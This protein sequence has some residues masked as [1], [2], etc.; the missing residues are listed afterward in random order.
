MA[1]SALVRWGVYAL[2]FVFGIY[3]FVR[4]ADFIGD[5]RFGLLSSGKFVEVIFLSI[6]YTIFFKIV[7]GLLKTGAEVA[8]GPSQARR[9]RR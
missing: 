7:V 5:L 3:I 9:F 8:A 2:L 1:V 6:V 4:V